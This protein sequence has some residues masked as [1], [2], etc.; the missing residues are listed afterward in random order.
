MRETKNS[1]FGYPASLTDLMESAQAG[2]A[3][4]GISKHDLRIANGNRSI[5]WQ[6]DDRAH[7]ASTVHRAP[8]H[9]VVVLDRGRL[10][11]TG[12]WDALI[13]DPTGAFAALLGAHPVSSVDALW[14]SVP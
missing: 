12:S 4:L 1:A 11:Q 10:V 9:R 2:E 8:C 3:Q 14:S 7:R 5:A 6:H 13:N